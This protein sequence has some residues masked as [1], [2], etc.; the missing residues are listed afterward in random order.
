[1][2]ICAESSQ[3]FCISKRHHLIEYAGEWKVHLTNKVSY[4]PSNLLLFRTL[5]CKIRG[6]IINK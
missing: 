5:L 6:F 1:M 3:I 2:G 4:T